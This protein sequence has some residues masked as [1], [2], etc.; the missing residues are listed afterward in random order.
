M[1]RRPP[2]STL[3]PYTTLFRSICE[4]ACHACFGRFR[5]ADVFDPRLPGSAGARTATG[6]ERLSRLAV[7]AMRLAAKP[8][9]LMGPRPECQGLF[10]SRRAPLLLFGVPPFVLCLSSTLFP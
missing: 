9:F 2:R 10:P 6:D 7:T 4:L 5:L 3:F 8:R 1:I